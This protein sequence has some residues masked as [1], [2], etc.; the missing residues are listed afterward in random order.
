M[1]IINKWPSS[2]RNHP[3][4]EW[5]Y[6]ALTDVTRS[7]AR[8][9]VANSKCAG[10]SA[11]F[12]ATLF[13]LCHMKRGAFPHFQPLL[14]SRRFFLH[15]VEQYIPAVS[16]LFAS[17]Q[18]KVLHR[19]QLDLRDTETVM[20]AAA[21]DAAVQSIM[22]EAFWPRWPIDS[23]SPATVTTAGFAISTTNGD[24]NVYSTPTPHN[25]NNIFNWDI[26]KITPDCEKIIWFQSWKITTAL[27]ATKYT[28]NA[29]TKHNSNSLHSLHIIN[30]LLEFLQQKQNIKN[31]I[32]YKPDSTA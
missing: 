16:T 11:V 28:I 23:P 13:P 17:S 1:Q 20:S 8:P 22:K 14:R 18:L 32:T 19:N 9:W 15:F 7:H 29:K 12:S 3:N 10:V 25:T 6:L 5:T 4:A 26:A 27:R 2:L 31:N 24:P 30:I 21:N